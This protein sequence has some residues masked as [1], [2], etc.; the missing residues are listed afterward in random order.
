MPKE[1][2][3]ITQA[4]KL[5]EGIIVGPG[6]LKLS[7]DE[8]LLHLNQTTAEAIMVAQILLDANE[9]FKFYG[10]TKNWGK[11]ST[12]SGFPTRIPSDVLTFDGGKRARE[13]NAQFES[14]GAPIEKKEAT[15]LK[16][17]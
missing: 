12:L 5:E 10:D 16:I 11:V 14:L 1:N 9:R 8:V 7:I 3:A 2:K 4:Y 13:F 6:N 17:L 15:C